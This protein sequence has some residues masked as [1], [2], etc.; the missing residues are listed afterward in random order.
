MTDDSVNI[1]EESILTDFGA[2]VLNMLLCE[3]AYE[4]HNKT[5]N[6]NIC[7]ATDNYETVGFRY[8][9]KIQIESITGANKYL[10]RP[11]AAKS[12]EEQEKRTRDK[13][14]VFTPSWVCNAQNNLIDD[15]WFGQSG[16]FNKQDE[17][18]HLWIP[19]NNK[20]PFSTT[21]GKTWQDYVCD[22]R[23]EMSCGEAPYLVSRY[24]ATTGNIIPISS[25]IG[26]FDRKLRVVGEN[27]QNVDE[28]YL[29]AFA[30]LKSTYGYEWQGDNLLLAREAVFYTF[31]DFYKDFVRQR[32]LNYIEP[33]Q[34]LLL[35]VAKIIS[36]NIFQMDG[37]KMVLPVS[38][39][40]A[41]L[42]EQSSSLD[43]VKESGKS[44]KNHRKNKVRHNG[45]RQVVADWNKLTWSEN[46][47]PVAIVEF[48]KSNDLKFNA[49][50]GNPPYHQVDGGAGA[51]AIP[52]YDSFVN[53]AKQMSNKYISVIMPS[54]WMTGGRGLEK[55]RA[56][57]LDD[58]HISKLYDHYRANDCFSNV[59]IKGGVC[60]FLWD[61]NHNK[62]CDI[63]T[64]GA[65]GY[66]QHS[67][68][69]LK[70]KDEKIFIRDPELIEIK[71]QVEIM[72]EKS[73]ESI[74]SSMK[75][76]G[77][78][79]D[80]FKDPAKYD[81]P[82]IRTSKK[83][84]DITIIGLDEKLHRTKRYIPQ[85]YPLPK[86]DLFDKIKLFVP[87][88]YGIGR[89]GEMPSKI[90]LAMPFDICTET[91]V[92]IGPFRTV[93]EAGNCEA[94]MRTKFFTVLVGIRKQDQGAGKSVYHY[95]PL[96]DFSIRWTDE[97]LYEKYQ[98]TSKQIDYINMILNK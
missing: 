55:F 68:R 57:M 14:E 8:N 15:A 48:H 7:W 69:F 74:V 78:R 59:E 1:I 44:D 29:W 5:V 20:I 56:S 52:I 72:G 22:N 19:N 61:K 83:E 81:L 91:F 3:H 64:Y 34:S 95:A 53:S 35:H 31:I 94:Y 12:K 77:L 25:R 65:N 70:E 90:E 96:Q 62:E 40:D 16:L 67:E 4:A 18:S 33:S 60:Y 82:P 32:K 21:K 98:L 58:T 79:G 24:D 71:R 63:H 43:A 23:M 87:R 42:K 37:I 80:F 13:G 66:I 84:D 46:E 49:I 51:S 27:V 97:M 9:D 39:E 30:A 89:I 92:Q 11:R 38:G 88:N 17:E 47:E 75:P 36:W 10:V 6:A 76:Y 86:R 54:R 26:I 85:D 28:W 45:I 2:D 73:F 93:E 41:R 50:V